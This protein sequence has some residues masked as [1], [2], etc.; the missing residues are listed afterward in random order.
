[1][2]VHSASCT[3]C[4]LNL[5]SQVCKSFRAVKHLPLGEEIVENGKALSAPLNGKTLLSMQ[6]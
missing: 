5:P 1:M 6:L 2:L 4:H 3:G